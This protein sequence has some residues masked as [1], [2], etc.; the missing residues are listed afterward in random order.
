MGEWDSYKEALTHYDGIGIRKAERSSW[1][2]YCQGIQNVP[3][4]ARLKK[5]MAKQATNTVSSVKLP[6]GRK[7]RTGREMLRKL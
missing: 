4:S 2:R 1:R 7:T 5:K 3:S 6:D